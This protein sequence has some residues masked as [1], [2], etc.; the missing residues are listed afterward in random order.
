MESNED[1]VYKL[2]MKA[3]KIVEN[4]KGILAADESPNSIQGKFLKCGI[5][6]TEESRRKFRELLF[7]TRGMSEKVGG[8]ILHEETFFQKN[9]EG[10]PFVDLL[11]SQGIAPGIKLD[12]GL[13]NFDNQ[14]KVSIGLEDLEKRL[15]GGRFA[16]AEFAKW[17]AVF[18]ITDST[19]SEEC[20][21]K[22]CMILAKYASICQKN[23]LLPIVEPEILYEGKHAIEECYRTSNTI[24][25]ATMMYLNV[26]KVNVQGVLIKPSFVTQGRY[27]N[28]PIAHHDVSH[29]TFLSLLNTIPCGVPGIVFLSGGH[30]SEDSMK[31]LNEINRETGNRTWKMSFSYGRAL[32]ESPMEVWKGKDENIKEAQRSFYENLEKAHLAAKGEL[33]K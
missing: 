4:G 29:Y 25:G 1:L 22:N 16:K 23:G 6:N 11:I 20:I 19:P 31:F 26:Y 17:R 8:V 33:N 21:R 30:S 27:N 5:E 3:K 24:L 18:N 12:K 2:G 9:S 13:E 14:E 15:K 7:S 10:V 28:S 32:T